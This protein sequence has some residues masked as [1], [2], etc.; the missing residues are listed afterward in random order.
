[1][2]SSRCFQLRVP[3]WFRTSR[4]A[5]WRTGLSRCVS[6]TGAVLESDD[7]PSV[8]DTIVVIIGLSQTGCLVGRGRVV[9]AQPSVTDDPASFVIAVDHYA[10]EHCEPILS[11]S[12]PALHGC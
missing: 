10:L 5:E 7:P 8:F 2:Q 11:R 4:E 6:T 1:M 9:R 3:V 12:R